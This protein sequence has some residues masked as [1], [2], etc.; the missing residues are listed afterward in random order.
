MAIQ[1]YLS[2]EGIDQQSLSHNIMSVIE[3]PKIDQGEY[4]LEVALSKSLFMS[5]N[6]TC[7]SVEMIIE[8]V[9]RDVDSKY[10]VIAILHTK[11]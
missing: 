4:E 9:V 5:S 10:E 6:S 8:Y 2:L 1:K 11:L 7:L 3:M